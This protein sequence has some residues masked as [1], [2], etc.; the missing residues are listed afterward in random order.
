MSPNNNAFFGEI[1]D[2]V[3]SSILSVE[4]AIDSTPM[5]EAEREQWHSCKTE[6]LCAA[7]H[8]E[9]HLPKD[10]LVLPMIVEAN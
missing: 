3:S 8:I 10:T 4:A 7:G 9:T 5:P 6:L 2:P 1:D